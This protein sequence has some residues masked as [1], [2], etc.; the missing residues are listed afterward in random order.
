MDIRVTENG[1]M[2]EAP[3]IQNQVDDKHAISKNSEV[4]RRLEWAWE[5]INISLERKITK[6]SKDLGSSS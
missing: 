5:T 6:K 4:N 3:E 2:G 1:E